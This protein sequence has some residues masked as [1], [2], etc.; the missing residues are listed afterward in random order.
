MT[1]TFATVDWDE[2]D[3]DWSVCVDERVD[4]THER[5]KDAVA[6]AK[7]LDDVHTVLAFTKS[8]TN[9]DTIRC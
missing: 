5:K 6:A 2:D 1:D 8:N 9:F 7:E 4:S 3:D